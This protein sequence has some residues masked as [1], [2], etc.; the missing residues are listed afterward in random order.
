MTITRTR[1]IEPNTEFEVFVPITKSTI[2]ANGKRYIQGVASGVAE[3]RDGERVTANCVK[4]MV[5]QIKAGG[6]KLTSSHQ[7]DWMTTIG[8]IVEGDA[9]EQTDEMIVK[10][11][12]P[13]AG[14]DPIADKA[15]KETHTGR[16]GFSV[17]GKL[18]QAFFERNDMGKRRKALDDVLLRHLCLTEKP[19][20]GQSFAEAVCKTWEPSE[21]ADTDFT[22]EVDLTK[23]NAGA[24]PGD[25]GQDSVIGDRR[26]AK[27][28]PGKGGAMNAGD[29]KSADDDSSLDDQDDVP[30]SEKLPQAGRHLACPNCGHEFGADLPDDQQREPDEPMAPVNGQTTKTEEA[31][32]LPDTLEALRGLIDVTKTDPDAPAETPTVTPPPRRRPRRLPPRRL[33]SRR[34]PTMISS[35][36]SHRACWRPTSASTTSR[37]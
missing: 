17:G 4:S 34:P 21:P 36:R 2:A 29:D 22:I 27:K 24:S 31:M 37:A 15:W 18:V 20:Y 19:A 25:S 35:P 14:E 8:D 6:I 33:R 10:A 16:L 5:R 23:D 26:P 30:A 28:K 9:D 32:A 13:A 12:L 11:E 3:D 1:D 7:Q